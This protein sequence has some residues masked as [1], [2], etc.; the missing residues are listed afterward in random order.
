MRLADKTVLITGANRGIGKA[1][2]LRLAREGAQ[3]AIG[4]RNVTTAVAVLD[5]IADS[6]GQAI[7]VPMDVTDS[8][9]CEAAVASVLA[10]WHKIDV[11]VNNAGIT[12]DALLLRMN[13]EQW[14]AVIDT[15]LKGVY[16]CSRAVLRP[17]L[18]AR[19]G[20]IINISS[21]V[22]ITGNAG[23]ANYAA[24]KAGIIGFTKSLALELAARNI[25]VNAIAPG[26]M[27]TEMTQ[28]LAPEQRSQLLSRIPLGKTGR[29]EDVAAATAFLVSDDAAYI[30]GQTLVIDGGISL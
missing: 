10:Q 3:V 12:R 23:Q 11:L 15:N 30:T 22:G 9:S 5:E 1:I 25:R 14:D 28:E 18:K 19:S 7:A 24:A 6:G 8:A 13:E 20:C 2:A 26:Y 29:P 27:E 17:M 4:A 21:V 16:R